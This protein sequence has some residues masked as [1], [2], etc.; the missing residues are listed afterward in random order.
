MDVM[1]SLYSLEKKLDIC[2]LCDLLAW[3]QV[4]TQSSLLFFTFSVK[5]YGILSIDWLG[6]LFLPVNVR[7]E[8]NKQICGNTAFEG[9]LKKPNE[10]H[11]ALCLVYFQK[12]TNKKRSKVLARTSSCNVGHT[13]THLFILVSETA[14]YC[15]WYRSRIASELNFPHVWREQNASCLKGSKIWIARLLVITESTL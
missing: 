1:V 6:S 10:P 8:S 12:N 15:I 9:R 7:A 13:E 14:S 2:F 3:Q 5:F 11:P 4:F